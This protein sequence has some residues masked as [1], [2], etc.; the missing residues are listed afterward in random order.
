MLLIDGGDLGCGELLMAVHPQVRGRHQPVPVDLPPEPVPAARARDRAH[1]P[2]RPASPRPGPTV[3]PPLAVLIP[4]TLSS[5]QCSRPGS[6]V[7][8][9]RMMM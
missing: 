1:R 4:G 3:P 9:D 5:G 7:D 2:R 8:L 6:A